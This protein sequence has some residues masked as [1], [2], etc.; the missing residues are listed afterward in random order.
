M[1]LEDFRDIAEL[2]ENLRRI[3]KR[4]RRIFIGA[5]GLAALCLV[6][7][8]LVVLRAE[9]GPQRGLRVSVA[10]LLSWCLVVTAYAYN[11][12]QVFAA[13]IRQQLARNQFLD[14]LT[15]VYNVRYMNRRLA[16]EEARLK[17]YGGASAVLFIDLDH[18]K[19][20]NDVHGHHIGNVAL[21][22]IATAMACKLRQC[23][24]LGRI[25]GD[26]FLALL[27]NTTLQQAMTAGERLCQ[28]VREFS[29]T[30][31]D[32]VRSVTASVG[33]G[34]YPTTGDCMNCVVAGADRAVYEAK[35]RGGG[36]VAQAGPYE[37][38]SASHAQAG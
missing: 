37:P 2:D 16:Q 12:L 3:E 7:L 32:A 28:T 22:R 8:L 33:V 20:V 29:M 1:R 6:L 15:E 23:D 4:M 36:G 27:P 11:S 24:M 35:K 26:E 31:Y 14:P 13:E 10:A 17:R 25:G 19:R 38:V 18:F 30:G 34:A 5:L 9:T 21:Q